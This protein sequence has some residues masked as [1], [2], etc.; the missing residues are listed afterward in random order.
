M[1]IMV[2][3]DEREDIMLIAFLTLT[4]FWFD[5]RYQERKKNIFNSEGVSL[6]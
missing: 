2:M 1:Q 6:I 4:Q 3:S 5:G